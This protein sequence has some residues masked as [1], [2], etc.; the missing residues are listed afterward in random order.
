MQLNGYF[1]PRRLLILAAATALITLII[2]F[3]YARLA[4]IPVTQAEAAPPSMQ[5]GSIFDSNGKLLAVSINL[6]DVGVSPSG[7]KD[8]AKFAREVAPILNEDESVILEKI[9]NPKSKKYVQL[10]K[11]IS[12]SKCDELKKLCTANQYR[13]MQFDC[14]PGRQYPEKSLA[15]QVIGWMGVNGKGLAGIELTE[16]TVL[17]PPFDP[18][19]PD[20]VHGNN[21]YLTIDAKLQ[22]DLEKIAVAAREKTQA[23]ALMLV[24]AEAKTGNIISYISLPAADLNEYSTSTEDE[25]RDLPAT[26]GYEPGSVFKLFSVASFLDSGA[27]NGSQTFYCDGI[28]QKKMQSGETIKIT[29]L[30]HHGSLTARDALKYS[31]N[32]AMAQMSEGIDSDAFL[33]RI[34]SFGF[35]EAAGVEV[36]Y[37]TPGLVRKTSDRFWSAR[38]K[39]TIAMGQEITVSAL[40]MIQAATSLANGGVPVQLT[41]IDKITD[42]KGETTYQHKPAFK[43][44]IL[45]K[46][47][48]DYLLSSM[49][50]VAREGTGHKAYLGD[51]SIGVKTGTAQMADKK[52]GYSD[53]DFISNCMAVFPVEDPEIVLYIVIIKAKGENY[54]GRI[55]APV[56][57]DAAN[58]IIDYRGMSRGNAT[59]L[60]HSG[61]VSIG[62]KSPVEIKE[63]VPDF[64]NMPMI[65]LLPLLQRKDINVILHGDGYVTSQNPPAGTPVTENMKIELYLE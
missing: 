36:P 44:R 43:N 20:N 52:G 54:A 28:Y 60:A 9:I 48:A 58:K 59:S 32:D 64:T 8:P 3:K 40:Q 21:I 62:Q 6:Y 22:F 55:V 33:D 12:Q 38:S 65:Q 63:K 47:T 39:P 25:K 50:T 42:Y 57:H 14:I 61:R 56:I 24:A 10:K 7:I 41:L 26:Y 35:G 15:S 16:Q 5:R 53:T 18:I 45:K 46:S 23:E 11:K 30:E 29:C 17:T 13:F 27:I 37:E 51:I 34:R 4:S 31:C 2:V 1:K 19:H 49:E